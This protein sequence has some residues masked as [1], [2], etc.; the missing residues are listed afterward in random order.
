MN[1]MLV[2]QT[3]TVENS[4]QTHLRIRRL[5][6]FDMSFSKAIKAMA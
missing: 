5:H 3:L 1:P 6:H 2:K 4:L